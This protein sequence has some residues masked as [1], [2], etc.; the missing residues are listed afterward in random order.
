M[1]S[2]EDTNSSPQKTPWAKLGDFL[3]AIPVIGGVINFVLTGFKLAFAVDRKISLSLI[4]GCG[5]GVLSALTLIHFGVLPYFKADESVWGWVAEGV[6]ALHTKPPGLSFAVVPQPTDWRRTYERELQDEGE[7][8]RRSGGS[9]AYHY[10]TGALEVTLPATSTFVL[11]LRPVPGY[12]LS[13]YAFRETSVLPEKQ[14]VEPL[15]RNEIQQD[16]V[17]VLRIQVP[18]CEAGDKLHIILKAES[19]VSP[20]TEDLRQTF[21]QSIE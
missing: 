18:R 21:Q 12:S 5:I 7:K 14:F 4:I 13:G 19:S 20:P 10:E 3:V 8:I 9:S 15:R 16:G 17:V 11:V 1:S 6:F 2:E